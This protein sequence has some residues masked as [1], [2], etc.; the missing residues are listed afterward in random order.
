MDHFRFCE[1]VAWHVIPITDRNVVENVHMNFR[2]Q[3]I[4]DDVL[5]RSLPD[6][7]ML[8]LEHMVNEN[9]FPI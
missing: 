6:G 7:F 4:E 1:I 2:I 3:V 8:S 5:P 9:S